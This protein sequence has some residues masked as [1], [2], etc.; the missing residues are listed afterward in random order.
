M[1][2]PTVSNPIGPEHTIVPNDPHKN[3]ENKTTIQHDEHIARLTQ[4]IENQCI[5]L[6][7]V[8]DLTNLSITLQS[9]AH[10]PMSTAPN[11]PHFPS[12]DS[13]V[14]EH[15]SPQQPPPTSNNPPLQIHQIRQPSTLLHKVNHLSSYQVNL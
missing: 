3:Y 4:E 9:P 10:E 11:L 15:F 6:N 7:Q 12:L 5:E 14:P 2:D 1:P 13:L 8:R